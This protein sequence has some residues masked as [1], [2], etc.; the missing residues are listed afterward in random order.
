VDGDVAD[1]RLVHDE[2]TKFARLADA[3]RALTAMTHLAS[4][5]DVTVDVRGRVGGGDGQHPRCRR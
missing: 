3:A 5:L 4:D 1:L 2:V